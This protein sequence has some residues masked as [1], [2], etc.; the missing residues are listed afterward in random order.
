[1]RQVDS[2]QGC[3]SFRKTQTYRKTGRQS[4]HKIRAQRGHEIMKNRSQ[5][6]R[7]PVRN[8]DLPVHTLFLPP[9]L[10]S[11]SSSVSFFGSP[12]HAPPRGEWKPVPGNPCIGFRDAV[13]S[14]P[15]FLASVF[16]YIVY[17]GWKPETDAT[18]RAF[19]ARQKLPDRPLFWL[20]AQTS[21]YPY[22][23]VR[24]HDDSIP[25]M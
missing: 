8:R 7:L 23:L 16:I 14:T 6:T 4:L 22:Q 9:S 2:L 11:V 19:L 15:P 21:K 5:K 24:F 10:L 3:Q 13:S 20:P 12:V 17:K 1:M 18:S 25:P